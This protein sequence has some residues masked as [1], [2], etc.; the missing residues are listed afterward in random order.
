MN[1]WRSSSLQTES[2]LPK[3]ISFKPAAWW[4]RNDTIV[5]RK[6]SRPELDHLN[7]GDIVLQEAGGAVTRLWDITSNENAL[8]VC[9]QCNCRCLMCPQ[10]PQPDPDGLLE[11]NLRILRLAKGSP[12]SNIGLTGGE[13][14]L[15]PNDLLTLLS[16]C[17]RLFPAASVSILTNGRRFKDYS[18]VK[19]IAAHNHPR[20]EFGISLQADNAPIH[21]S[22]MGATG[23]FRDTVLGLHNLA[24][25]RQR[26]E[27]RVVLMKQNVER[28]PQLAEFI[29]RNV[30]FAVH[31]AFMG[32]EIT[33]YAKENL[34]H[35][36]IDP[37]LYIP[38]LR[39]A[40]QILHQ[41]DLDV[42]I[43]NL[44]LSLLPPELHPFAKDS[45]SPWKKAFLPECQL[46][47]L[48]P[49]CPGLF[50]TSTLQSAAIQPFFS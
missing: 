45:I 49:H 14:L 8:M 30:P 10:P 41:R 44:P 19:K 32:L 36:W 28:L 35:I 23:S 31:I 4:K 24:L 26:V 3:K 43:F 5:V 11:F 12:V 47:R 29:Y 18:L 25:A 17:K 16:A 42:S 27:V 2:P 20:L 48:Q 1:F 7:E 50:A 22:I 34:N 46:C 6:D 13:P 15:R 37:T 40:T 39:E 38:Q 33:G 21:D 9:H